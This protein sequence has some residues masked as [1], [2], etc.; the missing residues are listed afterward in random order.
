MLKAGIQRKLVSKQKRNAYPQNIWSVTKEGVPLEAVLE[1]QGNG[2]Y[3]G[4]PMPVG[5]PFRD[6]VLELW[7]QP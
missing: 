4:Y 2:T 5:D 1:N 6:R 7:N 3:H